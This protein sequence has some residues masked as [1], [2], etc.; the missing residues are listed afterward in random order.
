MITRFGMDEGLGY[1]ALRH[2][3]RVFLMRLN[4]YRV[5]AG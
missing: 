1:V 2:R 4:W 5:A 3:G